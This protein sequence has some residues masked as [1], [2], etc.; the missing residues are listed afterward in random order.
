M[1]KSQ[2]WPRALPNIPNSKGLEATV[3]VFYFHALGLPGSLLLLIEHGVSTLLS[4]S[5]PPAQAPD[6]MTSWLPGSQPHHVALH[7]SLWS[8]TEVSPPLLCPFFTAPLPLGLKTKGVE[9]EPRSFQ[10]GSAYNTQLSPRRKGGLALQGKFLS[11]A[12]G[13]RAVSQEPPEGDPVI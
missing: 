13:V 9:R 2:R 6:V 8:Q 1:P 4:P 5:L 7:L 11:P 3:S 12:A 10:K